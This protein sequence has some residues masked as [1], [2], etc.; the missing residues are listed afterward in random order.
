M[1]DGLLHLYF[2]EM[3]VATVMFHGQ[4]C[5][6]WSCSQAQTTWETCLSI[7]AKR[8]TAACDRH[9]AFSWPKREGEKQSTPFETILR[10]HGS[11]L[12]LAR[13]RRRAAYCVVVVNDA[14]ALF[15]LAPAGNNGSRNRA[16]AASRCSHRA[17]QQAGSAGSE[18]TLLGRCGPDS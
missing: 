7:Q 18:A 6:P 16:H 8:S 14:V 13:M 9:R 3:N 2:N 12:P 4:G 11:K 5:L 10:F 1:T 15:I 17:R